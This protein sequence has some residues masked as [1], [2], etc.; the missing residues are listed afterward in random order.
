[1]ITKRKA[2]SMLAVLMFAVAV[3]V[4]AGALARRPDRSGP[5]AAGSPTPQSATASPTSH[6][7]KPSKSASTGGVRST[8]KVDPRKGRN[9]CDTARLLVR[10][11]PE[12]YGLSR[13]GLAVDGERFRQRLA[14]LAGT[15]ER[16]AEQSGD[17]ARTRGGEASWAALAAGTA[18]AEDRLRAVGLDVHSDSMVVEMA[19]L[20]KLTATE[21]PKA[22]ASLGTVCG[23]KTSALGLRSP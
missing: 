3:A 6:G 7:A 9:Y 2:A 15:F 4:V 16:L 19:Y 1:M 14:I 21:L 8:V 22:A 20:G 5:S 13:S 23:I 12:A 10:F 11:V 18:R 17:D